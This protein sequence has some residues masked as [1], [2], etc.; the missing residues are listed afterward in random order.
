MWGFFV[1]TS[2]ASH[3]LFTDYKQKVKS[4]AW[5]YLERRAFSVMF[6]LVQSADFP[7]Y[8]F[9]ASMD[10]DTFFLFYETAPKDRYCLFIP[11]DWKVVYGCFVGTDIME[12]FTNEIEVY[13]LTIIDPDE[14]HAFKETTYH[15]QWDNK[16]L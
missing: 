9:K 11:P 15:Y 16:E 10:R 1:G 5:P 8:Y 14:L 3:F 4:S 7:V 13:E 2:L 6:A 12:Y